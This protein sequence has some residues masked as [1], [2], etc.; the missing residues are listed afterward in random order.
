MET[1]ISQ[2][3]SP[4]PGFV[5]AAFAAAGSWE[6]FGRAFCSDGN[7]KCQVRSGADIIIP[8]LPL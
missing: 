4:L 1:A 5:L 2:A 6:N 7:L 3:D 8:I